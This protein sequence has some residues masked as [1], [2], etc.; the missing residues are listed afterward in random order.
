[1]RKCKSVQVNL[2]ACE[3]LTDINTFT[4]A[5]TIDSVLFCYLMLYST[6]SVS[7]SVSLNLN[8]NLNL[9]LSNQRNLECKM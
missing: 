8:L 7:V 3:L 1:M 4:D 5:N 6:Q 9:N 2:S